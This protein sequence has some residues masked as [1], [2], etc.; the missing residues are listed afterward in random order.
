MPW[1][2]LL[3]TDIAPAPLNIKRLVKISSSTC[4]SFLISSE[5][6]S[7]FL[8]KKARRIISK[9][10]CVGIGLLR[11]LS[12]PPVGLPVCILL[13]SK[14]NWSSSSNLILSSCDSGTASSL[15]WKESEAQ[16]Q[17]IFCCICSKCA[18]WHTPRIRLL[19]CVITKA[20]NTHRMQKEITVKIH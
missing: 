11:H 19:V 16:F 10:T 7:L 17:W 12:D 15:T 14:L 18:I 20:V 4:F 1:H 8:L 13:S 3:S 2:P 5:R 9:N 6:C